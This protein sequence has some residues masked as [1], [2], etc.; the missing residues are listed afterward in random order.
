[1]KFARQAKKNSSKK[2]AKVIIRISLLSLLQKL[3]LNFPKN[4][5]KAYE[6]KLSVNLYIQTME[7][8]KPSL[9][10]LEWM[11]LP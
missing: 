3:T 7:L 10:S 4:L 1:M 9:L 5:F 6:K 11:I 2:K 8:S